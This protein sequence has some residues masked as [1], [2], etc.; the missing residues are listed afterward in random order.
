[1]RLLVVSAAVSGFGGL[2]YIK[3]FG[4]NKLDWLRQLLPYEQEN[5]VDDTITR[6][7]RKLKRL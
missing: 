7:M 4:D 1:M 5:P 6:A 3:K 2:T